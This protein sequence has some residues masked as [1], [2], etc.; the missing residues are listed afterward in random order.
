MC[1]FSL[2]KLKQ[3]EGKKQYHVR[4]TN[5]FAALEDLDVEVEINSALETI[6]EFGLI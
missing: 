2:S 3:V 4:V 5:R 1:T 6:S